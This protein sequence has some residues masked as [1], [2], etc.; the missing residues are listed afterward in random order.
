LYKQV[1]DNLRNAYDQKVSEREARELIAWKAA[2]REEFLALLQNEGKYNL[3][4]VGAGTGI[5]GKFFQDN[6]LEV[7][8]TDLSP[9]M[10]ACCRK[11]G[12]QA[13]AMAFLNLDF[14]TKSFDAVF[15][16][17]C[18]LH[19][20][21]RDLAHVLVS[22]RDLLRPG[23]LFYWGQ[24]G[25]IQQEGINAEDHYTPK[26]FFSFLTDAQVKDFATRYFE[27]LSFNCIDLENDEMHYQ[28]MVLRKNL[29]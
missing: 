1:I 29:V 5:H 4:E 19:V 26:R 17:N 24:Y 2:E 12:L 7:I 6:G 27:L 10:V 13:H 23:G 22:V 15:A 18:L 28:G 25:G 16:M 3:L 9:N 14:P 20:P 11:K 21:R 8:C